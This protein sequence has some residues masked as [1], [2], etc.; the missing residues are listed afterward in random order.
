M[1][2][3]YNIL[4]ATC[5][6]R[7]KGRHTYRRLVQADRTGREL[8]NIRRAPDFVYVF[9]LK[10]FNRDNNNYVRYTGY[11]ISKYPLCFMYLRVF[12][13]FRFS[14]TLQCTVHRKGVFTRDKFIWANVKPTYRLKKYIF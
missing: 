3:Y 1:H 2:A 11:M 8:F 10:I 7:G 9:V 12:H 13:S 4:Y 5:F 6:S 14:D